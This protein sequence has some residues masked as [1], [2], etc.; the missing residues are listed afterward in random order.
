MTKRIT[1]LQRRTDLPVDRF[2]QHW[3]TTHAEIA[4]DLPGVV[5]YWQNHVLTTVPDASEAD[6][7]TVDGIVELWFTS[8]DVAQ[9]GTTSTTSERLIVDEPRFLSGLTGAPVT[10]PHPAPLPAAALWLLGWTTNDAGPTTDT[11]QQLETVLAALPGAGATTVHTLDPEG[12][13]LVREDLDRMPAL[14][15]AALSAGFTSADDARRAQDALHPALEDLHGEFRR[16][17][18]LTAAVV[19]IIERTTA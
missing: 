8:A 13:I 3:R 9:S 5:G 6:G 2:S 1:Y 17:R 10:D 16:F 12:E 11:L 14:P 15:D 7:F 19:P 18:S 4:V